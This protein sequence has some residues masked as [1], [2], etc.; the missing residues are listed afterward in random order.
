MFDKHAHQIF[1]DIFMALQFFKWVIW[2]KD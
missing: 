1:W 2:A